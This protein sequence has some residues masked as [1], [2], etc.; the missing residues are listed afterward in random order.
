ML[1]GSLGSQVHGA[2]DIGH[3]GLE[4]V[5]QQ[6]P[7]SQPQLDLDDVEQAPTV[8]QPEMP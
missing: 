7:P 5:V 2:A 3:G 8:R 4:V 1:P 6:V